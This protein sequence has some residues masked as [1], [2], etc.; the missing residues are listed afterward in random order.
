MAEPWGRLI[1]EGNDALCQ[2]RF[3]TCE[4]LAVRAGDLAP[5][6]AGP[7]LLAVAACRE[8]GRAAEAEPLARD[9]VAA[10]PDLAEA[11]ALL[12]AVLADL[13]RDAEAGRQ[14]DRIAPVA[15]AAPDLL[16]AAALASEIAAVLDATGPARTLFDVLASR[17][18]GF[19]P[20]T[21]AVARHVG[22]L[23]HVL[24]RW[25]EAE[26]HF[27][28]ALSANRAAGAPVFLAHTQRQYSALLR[29][30]GSDG[31]WERA[32]DLLA[33][34]AAVY[35]RLEIDRLAEESDAVLRRSQD[36]GGDPDGAT[37]VFRRAPDGWE[38]SCAGRSATVADS[39]GMDH[40]CALLAADGRPVHVAELVRVSAGDSLPEL[41]AA[42][43]CERVAHLD[44]EA[45]AGADPLA[46]A[47]ARAE[48][49]LLRAEL[50]VAAAGGHLGDTARRLVAVRIR[51]ALD[52]VE[53]AH[54]ALGR[55]LRRSIRTGI[56]CIYEP[57]RPQRWRVAA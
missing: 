50:A 35:R 19:V 52:R 18:G 4:R 16:V 57:D 25:E 8:Q 53:E 12:G 32:I 23:C 20:T 27:D 26:A 37:N 6:E 54:P 44:A 7:R 30:R 41:M 13:G 46:V 17:A 48:G 24:G 11:Q 10:H 36:P 29:A 5:G 1:R 34:A 14:L 45:A 33:E 2:A 3:R 49:D 42:E 9:A 15:V 55:H 56:F 31:D 39:S 51:I 38:L 43:Y 47:L 40:L 22:L 21:G 28:A